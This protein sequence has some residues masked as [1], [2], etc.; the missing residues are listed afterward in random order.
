[1]YEFL[2]SWQ[3]SSHHA[4]AV[5]N[6]CHTPHDFLRKYMTKADNGFFHSLSFT[7][8]LYPDNLKIRE[9]NRRK[10][11][12]NCLACHGELV[13]PINAIRGEAASAQARGPH[14]ETAGELGAHTPGIDCL[15]C[16]AAVGHG[17]RK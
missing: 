13:Q 17:P 4:V 9:V 12:E 5:C 2:S 11:L 14:G 3:H 16:H 8:H 15:H 10:L 7:F 1:M 6:D